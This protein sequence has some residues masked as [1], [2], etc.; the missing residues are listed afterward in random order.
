MSR[1]GQDPWYQRWYLDPYGTTWVQAPRLAHWG[2]EWRLWVEWPAGA[3]DFGDC[4]GRFAWWWG[5][6]PNDAPD[7]DPMEPE[8]EAV[9]PE[10]EAEPM[11]Q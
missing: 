3:R 6:W 2:G 9:Q 4:T 10:A 11:E 7:A 8:A 1:T 5:A